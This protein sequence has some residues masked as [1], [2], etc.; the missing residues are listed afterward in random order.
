MSHDACNHLKTFVLENLS[1]KRFVLNGFVLKAIWYEKPFVLN[2]RQ[3]FLNPVVLGKNCLAQTRTRYLAYFLFI[4][5]H[6]L[7]LI[8]WLSPD[9]LNFELVVGFDEKVWRKVPRLKYLLIKKIDRSN[10]V[11]ICS[12]K[13]KNFEISVP[14][15]FIFFIGS[16]LKKHYFKNLIFSGK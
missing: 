1:C 7:V 12:C 13:I 10:D 11:F 5:K 2:D 14:P 3:P 4:I 9:M 16:F 8:I 6:G 15:F